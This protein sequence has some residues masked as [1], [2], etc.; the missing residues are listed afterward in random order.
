MIREKIGVSKS[1]LSNWLNFI[2]FTP[3]DEVLKKI[4]KA[5]LKSGLFKHNEK[6]AEVREMQELAKKNWEKL[7]KEIYGSLG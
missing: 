6:L 1:T 2:P 7:Q 5:K 3:N 4:G